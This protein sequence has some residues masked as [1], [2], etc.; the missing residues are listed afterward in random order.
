MVLADGQYEVG[1]DENPFVKTWGHSDMC[2]NL[3]LAERAGVKAMLGVHHDPAL[4][5]TYHRG[6]EER[7]QGHNTVTVEL[8]RENR[9]YTI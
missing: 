2:R 8:A 9:T 1:S 6:L 7:L 4:D 3:D 5:D